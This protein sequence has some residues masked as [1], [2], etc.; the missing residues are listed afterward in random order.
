MFFF[1]LVLKDNGSFV[2]IRKKGEAQ[3][4]FK[5]SKAERVGKL[6]IQVFLSIRTRNGPTGAPFN[7]LTCGLLQVVPKI[8]KF[9]L[10]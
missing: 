5:K 1:R 7:L 4:T 10:I 8:W 6:V 2:K 3:E 9:Y